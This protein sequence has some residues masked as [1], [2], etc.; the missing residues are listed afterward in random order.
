MGPTLPIVRGALLAALLAGAACGNAAQEALSPKALEVLERTKTTNATYALYLRNTLTGEAPRPGEEW[1]AEFHSG[2]LHRV[3]T[4]RDRVVADCAAGTG[5][6]LSLVSGEMVEGYAVARAA[7]GISTN[8]TIIEAQWK[9]KVQTPFGEADRVRIVDEDNVREY[10]VSGEGILLRSTYAANVP[11]EPLI[12]LVQPVAVLSKL[13]D[14][15][16]FDRESLARSYVAETYRAAAVPAA[17]P[18]AHGAR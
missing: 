6:A 17:R 11:G 14:A 12:L 5:H 15:D 1:S 8:A 7:C 3:E 10:D 2:T 9:G 16:M 4:P 18:D 13:P